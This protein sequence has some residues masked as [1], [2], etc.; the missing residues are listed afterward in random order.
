V[1]CR[2]DKGVKNLQL[3]A[4]ERVEQL[5]NHHKRYF[6]VIVIG[7]GI[8]GAGIA[9]DAVT[10]GMKTALFDMQDFSEGTSSRSTKLVHGGLRYLKQFEINMVREVGKERAVVYENAPHVTIPIKMI[11][12]IYKS[13]TFGKLSTSLGLYVYDRLA[14][15]H[16]KERRKMLSPKE[17]IQR[18]P[19]L[20]KKDLLGSGC[21]VEYRT[22]DARLTIEVLKAAA[23]EG[24]YVCNYAKV[25]EFLYNDD[26]KIVGVAVKDELKGSTYEFYGKHIINATGPWVD[27]LRSLDNS[28]RG[29]SLSLTKG[30]HIVI[31]QAYFPL[32]N[33]IYFDTHDKRMIFAIPRD[34][35]T[36]IG[37]TDTFYEEDKRYPSITNEDVQY[38]LQAVNEMFPSV[39]LDSNHIESCWAGLR[40]LIQEEGKSPS[41]ISRKDEIWESSSGLITIAGGK[42][43]GYR[44]MAEQIVNII[45]KREKTSIKCQTKNKPLSGGNV[46]GTRG[47][48]SFIR[49]KSKESLR[50]GYTLEEGEYLARFYGSNVDRVFQLTKGYRGDS[51]KFK[52]PFLLFIKVLYSIKHELAVK[53][54]D[55]LIRRWGSLFFN[56]H[57]VKTYYGQICEQMSYY[58]SWTAEERKIY[59]IECQNAIENISF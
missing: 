9:L 8:T 38:L 49:E 20:K 3:S 42:L 40:P 53:P 29:K 35:K 5:R 36:Y 21:Y 34:K 10:R 6:D 30:V 25:V 28:V 33:A 26:R 18:E 56:I 39:S 58:L 23:E 48:E 50:Y 17:T 52:L 44:K 2:D 41:Q 1:K 45:E 27:E 19:L 14:N 22:D 12:P 37:T 43:T 4:R 54:T 31:D 51:S 7:G 15:V 24:A 32:K 59:L 16:K 46:G 11:L 47:F 57:E 55:L 13:G